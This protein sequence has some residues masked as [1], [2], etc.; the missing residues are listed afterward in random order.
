MPPKKNCTRKARRAELVF[1]EGRRDGPIH[2]HEPPLPS[3][4]NPRRVPTKPIDQHTPA[5]WVHPQFET[6]KS[7]VSKARQKRRGPRNPQNRGASH[8]SL[9]AGGACHRAIACKFPPLPFEN[10]EGCAAP[11]SDHPNCSR[12][13]TQR[14]HSQLNQG[15]A[16]EA[17][18]Q[19]NSPE[20]C[21]EI[22]SLPAPHPVEPQVFTPPHVETPEAPSV[23]N[24]R[25]DSALPQTSSHAWHP[26]KELDFGLDPCG[27]EEPAA[28]LVTDTPEEEYGV[29]VTWR[30]RP[31]LMEFL[32]ERG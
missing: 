6:T 18:T 31:R 12:K 2:C 9:H 25:C 26:E 16:A 20:N 28:V 4:E 11:A 21:R 32:R 3:A 29:K 27:S 7:V 30:R 22:L 14:S 23:R 15:A 5:A 19:M 13:D 8:S 10:S 24:W 17:D 1:L